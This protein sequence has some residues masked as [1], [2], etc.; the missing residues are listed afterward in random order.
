MALSPTSAALFHRVGRWLGWF[1]NAIGLSLAIFGL[2]SFWL[3]NG[4]MTEKALILATGILIFGLGRALRH[5][6]MRA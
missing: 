4:D 2:F 6:F 3:V 1:G 5:I